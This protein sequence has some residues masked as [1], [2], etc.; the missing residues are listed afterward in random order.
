MYCSQTSA[1]YY[2]KGLIQDVGFELIGMSGATTVPHVNIT[3]LTITWKDWNNT[4]LLTTQV[5][6]GDTPEYTG[7]TPTRAP[8]AQY[9]YT[10]S[11]W[12]PAPAP[13]SA[14]TTYTAQYSTTTN[15]YTVMATAGSHGSVTGSGTYNYGATA[16][17]VATGD[18]GY[19][20]S[21][22]SDGNTSNPRYITVTGNVTLSCTFE[23]APP[24]PTTWTIT[25][26][27]GLSPSNEEDEDVPSE[28]RYNVIGESISFPFT[29]N[30]SNY[31]SIG[32][33]FAGEMFEYNGGIVWEGTGGSSG[34]NYDN[35]NLRTITLTTDPS[36]IFVDQNWRQFVYHNSDWNPSM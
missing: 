28:N 9:T 26:Y 1:G 18:S 17:L 2:F 4:T 16:T 36:L 35:P 12:S 34:W 6:S 22:W 13:V 29:S 3:P 8:T 10:F 30:N 23:E 21:Q 19:T 32:W 33:D 31:T 20:F 15:Q 5:I 27:E 7:S 25:W 24:T 14:N 11:G